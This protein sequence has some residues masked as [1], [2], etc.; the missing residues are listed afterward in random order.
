MSVQIRKWLFGAESVRIGQ[1]LSGWSGM[2][3]IEEEYA[4]R[5]ANPTG[6]R[7]LTSYQKACVE[8]AQNAESSRRMGDLLAGQPYAL[9]GMTMHDVRRVFGTFDP[10]PQRMTPEEVMAANDLA[11]QD[12]AIAIRRRGLQL[13]TD[14]AIRDVRDKARKS[15]PKKTQDSYEPKQKLFIVD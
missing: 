7:E 4:R 5:E 1:N 10:P 8:A 6:E 14:A 12:S 3:P 15:R 9:T 11:D 2:S 13:S